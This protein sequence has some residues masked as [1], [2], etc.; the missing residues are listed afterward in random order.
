M[1]SFMSNCISHCENAFSNFK[2]NLEMSK[3]LSKS[4]RFKYALKAIQVFDIDVFL[5][6]WR[7][8]CF[9]KTNTW[10]HHPFDLTWHWSN[11][12]KRDEVWR[13]AMQYGTPMKCN[14]VWR[15][16]M[17]WHSHEMQ[18]NVTKC[19]ALAL[20]WNAMKCDG[21]TIPPACSSSWLADVGY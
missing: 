5:Q 2:M 20:I 14:E 19:N 18:W 13:N 10:S 6:M 1:H 7:W 16:A 21:Q 17:H 11:W 15:N 4:P 12:W 9:D 3:W 8:Y